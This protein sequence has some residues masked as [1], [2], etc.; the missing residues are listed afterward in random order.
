MKIKK[1]IKKIPLYFE[2]KGGEVKNAVKLSS[3]ETPF[4]MVPQVKQALIRNLDRMNRYPEKEPWRLKE[5]LAKKYGLR[6]ENIV[7]GNGS[8][9]LMQ[10]IYMA[11]I[12][13]GDSVIIPEKTF[14]MYGIYADIFGAKKII[15]PMPDYAIDLQD[16]LRRIG[17]KTRA[18]FIADPNNPTGMFLTRDEIARFISKVPARVLVVIDAAY[19]DFS[20]G[21]FEKDFKKIISASP[22]NVIF[23][24]TFSK[25]YGAAGLRFGYSVSDRDTSLN[26]NLMRQPF[27]INSAALEYAASILKCQKD[28]DER[29]K[30][31]RLQKNLMEGFFK[32]NSIRH[33]PTESNFFCIFLKKSGEF[34]EY[35]RKRNLYIRDLSSFKMPGFI[36]V[37]VSTAREN[38][39]FKKYLVE[40]LKK[41]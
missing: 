12:E 37:T 25:A 18:V 4:P 16:I 32:D 36:R 15:S 39:L 24:R 19:M 23:L 34:I 13:K 29:I 2:G 11:F 22:G 5:A 27:N 28:I 8:D 20:T 10:F 17:A 9:E 30:Y 41:R 40:F 35:C 14:S 26:I 31:I 33:L 21:N 7:L 6:G 1:S 3:N 38:A